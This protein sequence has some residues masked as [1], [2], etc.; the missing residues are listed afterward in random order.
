MPYHFLH[1][2][3][4]V[5]KGRFNIYEGRLIPKWNHTTPKFEDIFTPHDAMYSR[6]GLM[7]ID[8]NQKLHRFDKDFEL[9]DTLLDKPMHW[10]HLYV[11]AK[12]MN[13]YITNWRNGGKIV[14]YIID[15]GGIF[16]TPKDGLVLD[17]QRP[18]GEWQCEGSHL[19]MPRWGR[20]RWPEA[21]SGFKPWRMRSR[22][23]VKEMLLVTKSMIIEIDEATTKRLFPR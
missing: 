22:D 15:R 8:Y 9:A 18:E 19:Y 7:V 1:T 12:D 4:R 16:R 23:G 10:G 2:W 14:E 6:L 3:R 20:I 5:Q 11:Q 17:E 21:K 13:T